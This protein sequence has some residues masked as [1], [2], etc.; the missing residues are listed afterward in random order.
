MTP[1]VRHTQD[2]EKLKSFFQSASDLTLEE[3]D[4]SVRGWN[5]GKAN[6]IGNALHFD[7]EGQVRG[8]YLRDSFCHRNVF[9]LLSQKSTVFFQMTLVLSSQQTAFEVP[10]NNVSHCV[11]AKNEVTLEFHQNDDAAV[12]LYEMRFH[13]PNDASAGG[14]K[15]GEDKEDK[16][17][18]VEVGEGHSNLGRVALWR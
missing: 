12:S 9:F 17:D 3:K 15:E 11:T 14:D 7:V 16:D 5:W 4:L 13:V 1:H 18:P 6:F 8:S 10:L 2:F